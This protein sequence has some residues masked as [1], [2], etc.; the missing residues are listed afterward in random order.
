MDVV[1]LEDRGQRPQE[2]QARHVGDDHE[3][4]QAIVEP[5][6]GSELHATAVAAGVGDRDRVADDRAW[7]AVVDGD[8]ERGGAPPRQRSH[9]AV[10]VDEVAADQ[11]GLVGDPVGDRVEPAA[12]D[13]D[14]RPAADTPQIS[15][16]WSRWSAPRRPT[17]RRPGSTASGRNRCRGRPGARRARRRRGVALRRRRRSAH[18]RRTRRRSRRPDRIAGER[19]GVVRLQRRLHAMLEPEP[20]QLAA[21]R[22]QRP[23]GASA[24]GDRIDDHRQPHPS[25]SSRRSS[26]IATGAGADAPAP[27]AGADAGQHDRAVDSR[28][29]G[30]GEIGVEPVADHQRPSGPEPIERGLENRRSGLPTLW[31]RTPV[32]YSSAATTPVPGH[33]PSAVG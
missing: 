24:A 21:H 33:R 13:P 22:R 23:A 32:A 9:R 20:V 27:R 2:P 3:L 18:R 31:A 19:A 29:R 17:P 8:R 10:G 28:R 14:E 7:L 5:R 6:V 11:L 25:T 30:P 16:S 26:A 12:G 4:E 1:A 15:V